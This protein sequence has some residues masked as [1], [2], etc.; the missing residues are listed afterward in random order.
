MLPSPLQ[1]AD[2]FGDNSIETLLREILTLTKMSWN[3]AAFAGLM[4]ITRRF[5]RLVGD[6]M[7]GLPKDR[8]A[9]PQFGY[10]I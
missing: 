4:P 10:C 3:S 9:L 5:S 7:R 2:H 6:I 1:V 8:E